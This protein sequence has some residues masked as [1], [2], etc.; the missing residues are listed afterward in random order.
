M[1]LPSNSS[2]QRRL[3]DSA[4][5]QPFAMSEALFN[6][7]G[8][9]ALITGAA[10]GLGAA[11]AAALGHAGARL[12]L[13]DIDE[14]ALCA[15]CARLVD[16]GLQAEGLAFDVC[17]A[18]GVA[19]AMRQ[20]EEHAGR[21]DILVNNAGI[22]VYKGLVDHDIEDWNRV[23]GVDLTAL[24]VVARE[25]AKIMSEDGHG[26]I[27]NVSSILGLIS[28]PGIL[29]YVVAK[30]GVIGMTRAL[31]AELGSR[32]ITCNAIAPGFFETPMNDNLTADSAFRRMITSRTPLKRWALPEELSG[33]IVFLAS[34]ASSFVTGQ[35]LVV[36][37]GIT[38]S[39]FPPESAPLG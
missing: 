36:D 1:A 38:T 17:D 14:L 13:N 23:L 7:T 34:A 28:R 10:R 31:A 30:H 39:L 37:G 15:Q 20:I 3:L 4:I 11:M 9:A 33:P 6:L 29:S 24:Y 19:A 12:F 22:A 8:R 21:L 18:A 27:I 32:R 35:V 16:E 25:A 26:R 2:N 5:G